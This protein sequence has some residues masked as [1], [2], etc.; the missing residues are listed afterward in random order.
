MS[1][2]A[3]AAYACRALQRDYVDFFGKNS[4]VFKTNGDT[5]VLKYLLSPQNTRGFEQIDLA[6]TPMPGKTRPVAFRVE[7]PF[8]F[9]L[10]NPDVTCTT[11]KGAITS[12]DNEIVF[13]LTGP[14]FRVC[15]GNGDPVVLQFT[16]EELK[17]YCTKDDTTYIKRKIFLFLNRF[18]EALDKKIAQLLSTV[19]GTNANAQALTQLPF[20]VNNTTTNTSVPNPE[21]IW[22]LNQTYMNAGNDGQY[23]LLGGMVVKKIADYMKWLGLNAAGIDLSKV[24]DIN[25]Y[26]YYAKHLDAVLGADNFLQLSPGALQLVTYNENAGPYKT[27]VTD[28]YSNGTIVLP[29]TGITIDWDWRYDYECKVWR[30]DPYVHAELAVNRPGGCGPLATTN[31]IIRYEDCSNS[32]AAPVCPAP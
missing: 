28:L 24:D 4:A 11:T 17:K 16:R 29:R 31:G 27:E 30:F 23:A 20:F 14:A 12:S 18:E 10:C 21:A 7:Q 2:S 8:C 25:P 19:A 32:I 22:W 3:S 6:L 26:A 5:S 15:D 13:D 9:D 1:F